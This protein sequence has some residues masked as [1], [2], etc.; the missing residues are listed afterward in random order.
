MDAKVCWNIYA[1]IFMY[2]EWINKHAA[3]YIFPIVCYLSCNIKNGNIWDIFYLKMVTSLVLSDIF[4]R[5][6][7]HVSGSLLWPKIL[8]ILY[9]SVFT[10]IFKK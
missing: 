10:D 8:I 2:I 9:V 6:R 7:F 5:I 1:F 4:I 3:K